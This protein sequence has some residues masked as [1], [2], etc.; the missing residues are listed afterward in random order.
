MGVRPGFQSC[1][2]HRPAC[3]LGQAT[4]LSQPRLLH[5][6]MGEE[7]GIAPD[8]QDCWDKKQVMHVRGSAWCLVQSAEEPHLGWCR[9][10]LA[11][12]ERPPECDFHQPR[13]GRLEIK[14]SAEARARVG[15][16]DSCPHS[17]AAGV[18]TIGARD[19]GA[20]P[21]PEP[22]ETGEL[23]GGWHPPLPG[24][25]AGHIT[26]LL[27]RLQSPSGPAHPE[28]T[29]PTDGAGGPPPSLGGPP[30]LASGP[31]LRPALTFSEIPWN[32]PREGVS[33]PG[34]PS[35]AAASISD[36]NATGPLFTWAFPR[37][38]VL[39]GPSTAT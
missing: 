22:P 9:R 26:P 29:A 1:L 13:K 5:L 24:T 16:E 32:Q 7:R 18:C 25:A 2:G 31:L 28:N 34:G 36:P 14:V 3:G 23:K 4:D 38:Q 35:A 20:C 21:P 6:Q 17:G 19:G 33:K 8:T 30:T 10:H 39:G 11:P 27:P 15:P 12:R 37:F